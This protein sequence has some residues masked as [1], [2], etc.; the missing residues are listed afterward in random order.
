MWDKKLKNQTIKKKLS[1]WMTV[2]C[3]FLL[4]VG[5]GF[6]VGS[7][8]AEYFP[9]SRETQAQT[10]A[11]QTKKVSVGGMPAG[12]YMETDG[13]LI[14]DTQ[15]IKGIDGKMYEPAQGMV[16][17]GDYIKAVNQKEICEKKE[18][19]KELEK[20]SGEKVEL[21]VRR[22][23]K[24]VK[25]ALQAVETAA[26]EYKLGI[27]VRDNVQ[28]LGTV[29]FLTDSLKKEFPQIEIVDKISIFD[30]DTYDFDD[31]DLI[32]TTI[33]LPVVLNKPVIRVNPILRK[34]DIRRID[35]FLRREKP[36]PWEADAY[37]QD[38]R[39]NELLDVI[40]KFCNIENEEKLTHELKKRIQVNRP[41]TGLP[42]LP[43]FYDILP[44][45]YV[46]ARVKAESWEEAVK[47]AS[48]PLLEDGCMTQEYV[49]K[50]LEV[51]EKYGQYSV[52]SNG[53]CMAHAEPDSGYR[54]ACSLVTLE[55]P[56]E[57][58][59]DGT[60]MEIYVMM[61]LS[62][63]DTV[64]QARALDELFLLLDEFPEFPFEL[65]KAADTVEVFRLLR[66]YYNKSS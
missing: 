12:I 1:R 2:V 10:K 24:L 61:V 30:L 15:Q 43:S 16:K 60:S 26:G 14:L 6:S 34:I 11:V 54:L 18:L 27:W 21:T 9:E 32:V 20:L 33:E 7:A 52:I 25:I 55:H 45:K 37:T 35:A 42:E 53:I 39:V 46:Q 4:A 44:R 8:A 17:S 58:D 65:Q 19:L 23:G 28:G 40:G 13:V 56:V 57:I 36:E 59:M 64:S 50:M 62:L 63:T 22:G 31:I 49:R 5:L 48:V 51:K 66:Y 29:T 41:G 3:S 47:A 38:I